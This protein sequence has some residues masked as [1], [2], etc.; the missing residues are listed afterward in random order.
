[1]G[2]VRQELGDLEGAIAIYRAMLA[3]EPD[4]KTS[5]AALNNMGAALMISGRAN[6]AA[7]ALRRCI[8]IDPKKPE[9]FVNLGVIHQEDGDIEGAT[10]HF[11]RAYAL[12]RNDGF[13]VRIATRSKLAVS[14]R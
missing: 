14:Y 5:G 10:Q 1:M 11:S 4:A 12:Q 6:E 7:E 2:A 9:A 13:R 3:R 8:E